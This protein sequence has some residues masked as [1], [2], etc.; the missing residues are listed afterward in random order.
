MNGI[1]NQQQQDIRAHYLAVGRQLV[2]PT[3]AQRDQ[4]L[5]FDRELW[6][7]LGSSG[8]F[9]VHMPKQYGGQG[10]GVWEFSAA[11][12]GF[13][14]GCQDMGVLVS[15][16]A[17]VALV[18]AALISYGSEEQLQ[19]WLPPLISGEKIGCFAITEQGCG[20]D[21]RSLKL[22]ARRDGNGYRLNGMKW[23]ITNAPVAD[24][25]MTFARLEEAGANAISC[26]ITETAKPGLVQSAPFE[27]MGNRG[28]PIGSLSFDEVALDADSLVGTEGQG[29]R[30]LYF[31]FLVERIFTGVSIVGC[32]QPVID[33]CLQYSLKREAFGRPISDNQYVQG[34]IVQ[35]YT[36]LEL[37]R[38]VVGRGLTELEQGRDCST[39]ASIIKMLAS[40]AMHE[41]CLNAM[42]IHGNYG[43]RRDFHFERLLRDSI[44][45]FFAGGTSEIHKTVIWANLVAE[46]QN[47]S[48]TKDDLRLDAYTGEGA[49]A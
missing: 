12:E 4:E 14:E 15:F 42:R 18:Q 33:E 34:H 35:A 13:S 48:K 19:R 36:Q 28:T 40:E 20:S 21:V 49:A 22:A 7:S 46:A 37:L 9:G 27:L 43:Y 32:M 1:W 41:A 8:L 47:R 16:V 30:V 2:R 10:L 5:G 23:N 44:G 29:L 39:L 6:R 24:I 38:S 3:S 26:F 31:G 11:L 25:C 45:L 17:Q